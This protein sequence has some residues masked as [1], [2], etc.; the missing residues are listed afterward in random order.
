MLE[1]KLKRIGSIFLV[2]IMVLSLWNVPVYGAGSGET[3]SVSENVVTS[4]TSSITVQLTQVPDSG[5]LRVIQMEAGESYDSSK[6]NS[7]TSLNFTLAGN[8]EVGTNVLPLSAERL[9]ITL[10]TR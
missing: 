3:V 8:L 7:Y 2:L 10:L 5:I 4:E 1:G 9:R 6:L